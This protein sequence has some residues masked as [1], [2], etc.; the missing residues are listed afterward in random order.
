MDLARVCYYSGLG[1]STAGLKT[2]QLGEH[3]KCYHTKYPVRDERLS[4]FLNKIKRIFPL[5]SVVMHIILSW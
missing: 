5:E 4:I 3:A 1:R 2:K